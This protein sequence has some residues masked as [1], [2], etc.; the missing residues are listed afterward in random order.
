M[1]LNLFRAVAHFKGPQI[2]VATTLPIALRICGKFQFF[3]RFIIFVFPWVVI[4]QLFLSSVIY[5]SFTVF[6][7][8][9]LS[10]NREFAFGVG[11]L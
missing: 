6:Q 5:K 9:L 3:H 11:E 2:F 1:V 7:T 10:C 8:C 4:V